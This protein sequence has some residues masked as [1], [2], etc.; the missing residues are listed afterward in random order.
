[1]SE[2]RTFQNGKV[3]LISSEKSNSLSRYSDDKMRKL[4]QSSKKVLATL[5]EI[6]TMRAMIR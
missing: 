4:H 5:N 3:V 6:Q 2:S 1:M